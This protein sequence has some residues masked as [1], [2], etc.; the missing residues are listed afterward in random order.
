MNSEDEDKEDEEEDEEKKEE[1]LGEEDDDDK[2]KERVFPE[3]ETLREGL[4]LTL[5]KGESGLFLANQPG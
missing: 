3:K 4:Q 1:K 5:P 2:K